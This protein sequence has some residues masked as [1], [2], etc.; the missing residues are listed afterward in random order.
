[1]ASQSARLTQSK[2]RASQKALTK[3]RQNY[4]AVHSG[5]VRSKHVT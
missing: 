1:M 3:I 5:P 2:D 4:Q